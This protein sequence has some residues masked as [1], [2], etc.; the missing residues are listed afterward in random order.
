MRRKRASETSLRRCQA[1]VQNTLD[2]VLTMVKGT[3]KLT[4]VVVVLAA[5]I[6][7]VKMLQSGAPSDPLKEWSYPK[8]NRGVERTP[9][10]GLSVNRSGGCSESCVQSAVRHRFTF[11]RRKFLPSTPSLTLLARPPI[12]WRATVTKPIEM[13]SF[14]GFRRLRE[15][16]P[17]F[18]WWARMLSKEVCWA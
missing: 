6:G 9:P 4:M 5:L 10:L 16:R 13:G 15:S 2:E 12:N 8:A 14:V 7:S 18:Q 11:R 3:I 17:A 1:P